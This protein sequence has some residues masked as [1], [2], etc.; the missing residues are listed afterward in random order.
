[1][2]KEKSTRTQLTDKTLPIK[3]GLV[4]IIKSNRNVNKKQNKLDAL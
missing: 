4:K 2:Y 1:M 3:K